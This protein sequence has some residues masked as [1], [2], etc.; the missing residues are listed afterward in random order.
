M[1]TDERAVTSGSLKRTVN[2]FLAVADG[3]LDG[4]PHYDIAQSDNVMIHQSS[5]DDKEVSP[6]WNAFYFQKGKL[7][8]ISKNGKSLELLNF[9][10]SL[11]FVVYVYR[12]LPAKRKKKR[13]GQNQHKFLSAYIIC[14]ISPIY[15]S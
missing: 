12:C 9:L 14:C 1:G 4:S 3:V 6:S 11:S 7:P 2:D 13:C 8:V 10:K 5:E 15:P